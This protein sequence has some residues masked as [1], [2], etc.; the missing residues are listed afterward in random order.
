MSL[1]LT[2]YKLDAT[3]YQDILGLELRGETRDENLYAV[4]TYL[5]LHVSCTSNRRRREK[6]RERDK[7]A[8]G[9]CLMSCCVGSS[10]F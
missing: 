9:D 10:E 1:D 4:P 3:G 2:G 8:W 7:E 5:L 6:R